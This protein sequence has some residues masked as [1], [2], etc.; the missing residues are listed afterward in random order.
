MNGAHRQD[1][2]LIRMDWGIDGARAISPGAVT[3]VLVDVLS[4][5]TA[6]SVAADRGTVVLPY[7]WTDD[8]AAEHAAEHAAVLAVRRSAAGPGDV[9]LSPAALRAASGIERL[10]LP[11]PNGSAIATHLRAAGTRVLA[12]CLRNAGAV[13]DWLTRYHGPDGAAVAVVGAGERWPDGALR[14]AVEDL[15]GAGAVVAAMLR[16]G[17]TSVS[18]EA[19]AAA[20]AFAEATDDLPARL[21]ACASGAE[22]VATG[23]GQ[24]VDIAAELDLSRVVPCLGT[25]GFRDL[26]RPD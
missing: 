7:P 15:W 22:L 20:A 26:H 10:V 11:S 5:T 1:P 8:G 14:P 25:S 3:T 19:R 24:D 12:A 4:F 23:Y 21:S 18:P 9:T 17:W 13:A 2:F 6:V 16:H